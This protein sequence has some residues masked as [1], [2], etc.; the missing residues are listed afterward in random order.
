MSS[1]VVYRPVAPTRPAAGYI[2]GKKQLAKTIIAEIERIP[3]ETYAEPF[4]GMGGVFLRRRLAARAEVINDRSGDVATFFR[5]LQRHYVPLMDMLRW[6]FTGRQE[7]ERLKASPPATLTDLERAVRFLYLQRTAFGGKVSGRNFGV[8]VRAARFNVAKLAPMLDDLH[9]RLAGVTI[10]CL[11]WADFIARYDRPT[12]LFY[13][14][15]PY[16]GSEDDY[17]RGLFARAEYERMAE[18]LSG[19]QGRFILS[20]NDVPEIR[21]AFARFALKPVSLSYSLPGNG[22]AHAARELIITGRRK[23]A[24]AGRSARH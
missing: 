3:H 22:K 23:R 14:D 11:P 16:F 13:L 15:P 8:D 10:E 9:A 4:V 19:L 24:V 6:Q 18:V 17:G 5:V 12:T 2:G 1:K 20:I 21:K 7:F